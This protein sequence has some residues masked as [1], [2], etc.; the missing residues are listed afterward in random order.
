MLL[1]STQPFARM[2]QEVYAFFGDQ[3]RTAVVPFKG[4]GAPLHLD[5]VRFRS[6]EWSVVAL[7][8]DPQDGGGR[9]ASLTE[10]VAAIQHFTRLPYWKHR[11]QLYEIWFF[12]V[13]LMVVRNRAPGLQ[14]CV[15]NGVWLLPKSGTITTIPMASV[16]L[17]T[18]RFQWHDRVAARR[19]AAPMR[20]D[21]YYQYQGPPPR[22]LGPRDDDA[23][24]DVLVTLVE[25]SAACGAIRSGDVLLVAELKARRPFSWKRMQEAIYSLACWEPLAAMGANYFP[26]KKEENGRYH[27]EAFRQQLD[28]MA[29]FAGQGVRPEDAATASLC[30]FLSEILSVLL[31]PTL[32]PS[33]HQASVNQLNTLLAALPQ[34]PGSVPSPGAARVA[35]PPPATGAVSK[36]RLDE[37]LYLKGLAATHAAH[38]AALTEFARTALDHEAIASLQRLQRELEEPG[39][40]V[41]DLILRAR[42]ERNR[43]RDRLLEAVRRGDGASRDDA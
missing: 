20:L 2:V 28:S 5:S 16:D 30:E 27:S 17:R 9:R 6:V 42:G 41:G 34:W 8:A 40:T 43:I 23:R 1:K 29:V 33:A 13:L 38:I 22:A 35:A 39:F 15:E 24:P 31:D 18:S 26:Q 4:V 21:M 32:S 14:L 7:V 37:L 3:V 10:I 36:A 19:P 12:V 11:W 25:R